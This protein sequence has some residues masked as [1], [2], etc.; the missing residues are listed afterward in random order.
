MLPGPLTRISPSSAIFS[1][2]HSNGLPT[3]RNLCAYS[4]FEHTPDEVSVRPQPFKIGTPRAQKNSST[5]LDS[6]APPLTK[7]RR[8]PPVRSVRTLVSTRR[9]AIRRWALRSG[10][11]FFVCEKRAPT[12]TAHRKTDCRIELD[13]RT[14]AITAAYIFSYTR[15]T[16]HMTVGLIS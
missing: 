3:V 8:R 9:S 12:A 10:P 7:K 13:L 16:L 15:G 4:V 11:G 1:W 2:T 14:R 5:S 6:A